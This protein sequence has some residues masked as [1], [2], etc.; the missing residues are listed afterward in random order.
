MNSL[1]GLK[2]YCPSWEGMQHPHPCRR[3]LHA[4]LRLWIALQGCYGEEGPVRE[5]RVQ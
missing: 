1:R 2:D 4:D 5:R 3:V